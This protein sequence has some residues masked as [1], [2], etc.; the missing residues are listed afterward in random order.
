[1]TLWINQSESSAPLRV[2]PFWLVQSNGT[3]VATNEAGGRPQWSINGS[4]FTNAPA[5]LSA[6]SANA[7]RYTLQLAQS[8]VSVPGTM[9]LRHSSTTCFEQSS[10]P[11]VV[12]IVKQNPYIHV[13]DEARSS[14]TDLNSYGWTNQ[15]PS[16]KTVQGFAGLSHVTLNST[17]TTT[18]DHFN[19]AFIQF[20]YPDG[21][22]VGNYIS[23][24]TG[25]TRGAYLQNALLVAGASGMSYTILPS[26]QLP[27]LGSVWNASRAAYGVSGSFGQYTYSQLTGGSGGTINTA[28][29]P[30]SGG[31]TAVQIAGEVWTYTARNLNS[32]STA[33]MAGV[34]SV[35]TVQQA[36]STYS[37]FLAPGTHSGATV[38]GVSNTA[39]FPS[40][41]SLANA[42]AVWSSYLTRTLQGNSSAATIGFVQSV[43]TVQQVSA[44]GRV[45][46]A[47]SL[48]STDL[49]NNRLVQEAL[50]AL[51]NRVQVGTSTMTVYG[52]DDATPAWVASV[53]SG[54]FPIAS[55]DPTG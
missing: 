50:Y 1:M 44:L 33:T 2:V 55:T 29:F 23:D 13:W 25:S 7:G 18:N 39:N 27:D 52:P 32:Y 37:A 48:L 54:Q 38:G 51:R 43:L 45:A 4:A 41:N 8:D 10:I 5:T 36:A 3:S 11:A 40:S 24:Y 6:V 12:Q 46:M 31:S 35:G 53:T 26:A 49:G 47:S 19:G 20:Q 34:T 15:V 22:L 17:E 21:T 9:V 14:H 30:S 28:N 16:A 42:D